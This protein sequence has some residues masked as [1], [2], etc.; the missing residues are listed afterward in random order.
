MDTLQAILKRRS[1]R[2]FAQDP[3][4]PEVLKALINAARIA[5]SAANLQPLEFVVVTE[6]ELCEQV[7]ECLKWAAYTTPR[8]TPDAGHRPT[9]YV[10]MCVRPEYASPVG[11]DYDLGAAAAS[12]TILAVDQG[13]GSCWIKNINSPKV[14]K[15]LNLPEGL[16]LDSILALGVPAEEPVQ[17]DL[18]PEEAGKEV[19][20][21]WRDEAE[22]Q[23]VPKRSLET[24]LHWERHRG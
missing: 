3:I 20:K 23:F 12:L 17:V 24:V 10:A 1:V 19:I 5:P 11:T 6:P 7:F 18:K 2:S 21:Y 14:S 22:Q 16:K 15:L 4:D 8:G 9:A 13:L